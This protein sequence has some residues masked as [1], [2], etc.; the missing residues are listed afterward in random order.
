[1]T[2]TRGVA[3]RLTRIFPEVLHVDPPAA[4]A[5]LF[6]NGLIDSL[7][8]VELLMK[9][10]QE[11]GVSVAVDDL[12]LENFRTIERIAAFVEARTTAPPIRLVHQGTGR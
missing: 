3:A 12:E 9:L 4:D 5:D 11:F 7:A 6:E 10:E 2:W 8:F 1:M